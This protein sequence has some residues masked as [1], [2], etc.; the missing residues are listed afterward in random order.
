MTEVR[1]L[2]LG[3]GVAEHRAEFDE[4]YK[5]V[6]DSGWFLLGNELRA[7]EAEFASAHE[8]PACVGVASGLDALVLALRALG[9]SAGDEVIVPAHTF[10]ATWLSVSAVGATPVPVDIDATGNIDAALIGAAITPRTRA[11]IPVHLYGQPANM[12]SISDIARE[13]GIV[14]VED[15]A[16]AHLAKWDGRFV[17]TFGDAAAFSFYP[18]KNVGAFA[19]GGAVL[20]SDVAVAE[21][22][23]LLGNYGS[24]IKYEHELKGTNSRLDEM[25]AAFLRVR[26][27]HADAATLRRREL[28]DYYLRELGAEKNFVTPTVDARAEHVWHL[29]TILV[30][31][32]EAVSACLAEKGVQTLV[33]YP[34]PPHLT[35]AYAQEFG[36]R[37]YPVSEDMC[38]RTLSLPM[39]PNVTSEAA[40]AVV[41]ALRAALRSTAV[42]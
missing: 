27:R 14:V 21:R 1:F 20:T 39:G 15:A 23:R 38:Q 24:R 31:D 16:Q 28:A 19:D 10:I 25:Q 32:R 29:F 9:V 4:A 35:E 30:D 26:L 40:A 37:T 6:M 33:H 22:V 7:F 13:A 11:V 34:T 2:D 12:S 36:D 42:A 5:R 17:G 3:A 41:N 18:G 8:A